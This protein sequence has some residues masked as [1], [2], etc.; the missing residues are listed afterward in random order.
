MGSLVLA[1][2]CEGGLWARAIILDITHST[3]TNEGTCVVKF[4]TQGFGEIEI[5]MQNIFPLI[6]NSIIILFLYFLTGNAIFN[7]ILIDKELLV[8]S[9]D[10]D[11]ESRN[12][13]RDAAIV[14]KV[15]LN[16]E[17]IQS[18][19]SWEKHTKVIFFIVIRIGNRVLK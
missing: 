19:G 16:T 15:L 2:S 5:P 18:L 11:E 8:I 4:E 1:K 13:E 12:T 17:P 14:N 7:C 10:S 6:D 3:S 9:S